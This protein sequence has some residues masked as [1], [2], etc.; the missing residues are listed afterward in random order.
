METKLER[1][2]EISATTKKPEFTALYHHIS[3]E[4]LK[5]CHKELDGKKAV[6]IDKVTKDEYEQNLDA[7]LKDLVYRLKTRAY[8][9][10]PSLRVWIPKAN[11]K[12]RPL[13]IASYEDKIV[14]LALK[15]VLE[16]IYE[17][18]F[19]PWMCGFRPNKGC[20]DAIKA[21]WSC[22]NTGRIHYIVDADIKGFFDHIDH[23][24]MMKFVSLYIKDPNILW[25]INSYLKAGVID[26]KTY[27][28]TEEGTAQGNIISPILANIYM[29]NVLVLWY[30]FAIK[31]NFKGANFLVVY[32]DDFIAGFELESEAKQYY[33]LLK[34][35]MNR[36]NL[37]LEESKS[38]LIAFSKWICVDNERK[39]LPKPE[40][41]DFLGF[42]FYSSKT[43]KGMPTVKVM[44]ASKKLRAKLSEM[45]KWLY[46]N[47]TMPV[48]ELI[49]AMNRKLVGHYNYYGVSFNSIRL[50]TFLHFSQKYLYKVLNRRSHKRSYTSEQFMEF[51]KYCP[52]ARPHVKVKLY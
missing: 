49:K 30:R 45:K 21:T 27:N 7:N 51:L 36:F 17:P 22:I 2:A 42:T 40:T 31:E 1:I 20:H 35:R 38:R 29:H 48:L 43:R 34:E 8:K 32:A 11:G 5:K 28:A 47:R 19:L 10:L 24:W 50:Q 14:Q 15:K 23:D 18:R 41:F 9:P 12:L 46:E 16:A 39:G 25:L 3:Y 52:L 26:N 44:T 13:G 33:E 6:G 37:E 4:L